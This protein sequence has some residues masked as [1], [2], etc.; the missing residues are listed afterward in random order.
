MIE[1]EIHKDVVEYAQKKLDHIDTS[2]NLGLS[3]FGSE[4]DRILVGYIGERIVMNFLNIKD[5]SDDYNFDLIS[6]KGKRLEVK[7]ITAKFKPKLHYLCTVNSHDLD[8]VHKQEADYYI[9]LRILNDF[10]KGWMLGWI[11]CKEFFNKGEFVSK[12]KD[13]GKFKFFKANATVLP[14]SE[15]NKFEDFIH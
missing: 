3:K 2:A 4:K 7:T 9:F 15:L 13:F 10:S 5:D 1:I 11:S 12:G 8:G 14:I 6:N